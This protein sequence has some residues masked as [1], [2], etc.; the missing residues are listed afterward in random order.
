MVADAPVVSCESSWAHVGDRNVFVRCKVKARPKVTAIF[1]IL[2]GNGTTVAEGQVV[3]E[4][5]TLVM[6]SQ[7]SFVGVA[8][9][10]HYTYRSRRH[11]LANGIRPLAVIFSR[12]Y[13]PRVCGSC[14]Y[15]FVGANLT[16][17]Q[18][19]R[20]LEAGQKLFF[21]FHY[22]YYFCCI[23]LSYVVNKDFHQN[24]HSPGTGSKKK[25]GLNVFTCE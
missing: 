18:Q 17:Y 19:M 22:W 16:T 14:A 12:A 23:L 20:H 24:F 7:T 13:C 15:V 9:N 4:H 5:W 8:C 11:I 10:P 21:L 25:I 1:W 2:D 3:N 6:V